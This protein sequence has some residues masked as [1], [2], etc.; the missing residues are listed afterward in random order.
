MDDN[1][2]P[3]LGTAQYTAIRAPRSDLVVL[4][5]VGILPC[6][7]YIAELVQ[8]PER[9]FPPMWSMV[10]YTQ[11]LC[12]RALKPFEVKVHMN[13]ED[14][15][16]EQ[17]ITVF[18]AAGEN[19]VLI[20]N[21]IPAAEMRLAVPESFKVCARLQAPGVNRSGHTGCI[22][23][24]ADALMPAIYYTAFGPAPKPECDAFVVA[25][26]GAAA[27]GGEV[28]WPKFVREDIGR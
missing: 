18:D 27:M 2:I 14:S 22:V 20:V 5:A 9:I 24:P 6:A 21:Q 12:L 16:A 7:N 26:C 13:I 3:V 17:H 1:F 25:S 8:R 11:L 19:K 23:V 10:F 15:G 4:T 28:P